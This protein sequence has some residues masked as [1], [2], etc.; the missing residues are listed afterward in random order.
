MIQI[1]KDANQMFVHVVENIKKASD[2]ILFS[3]VD[4]AF[5][6]KALG[7]KKQNVHLKKIDALEHALVYGYLNLSKI[8]KNAGNAEIR[9]IE[10]D[11]KFQQISLV[12]GKNISFL[13]PDEESACIGQTIHNEQLCSK[14]KVRFLDLYQRAIPLEHVLQKLCAAR[15]TLLKHASIELNND[16][17]LFL[18]N[19]IDFGIFAAYSEEKKETISQKRHLKK[20]IKKIN[21]YTVANLELDSNSVRTTYVAG[22]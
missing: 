7:Y 22:K 2:E 8:A 15:D 3:I 9:F 6:I 12:D 20:F 14:Y 17:L 1:A 16:E 5:A 18:Q 13:N 19:L 4:N 10:L 21:T 11:N